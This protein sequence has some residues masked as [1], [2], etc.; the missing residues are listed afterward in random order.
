MAAV[1]W[2]NANLW[3]QRIETLRFVETSILGLGA[4]LESFI[5]LDRSLMNIE[6]I[7]RYAVSHEISHIWLGIHTEYLAKGKFFLGETIPGYVNL[8]YYESWAGDDAF[9]N[10]IQDKI[11]L[12]LSEVPFYTVAFEQ[13]LNQRKGS[14][15]ADDIIYHKGVA[16]VHEFRKLIGKEKLLKI[17][18]ETYSV[19]NHFVNLRD[20]EMNIK[21][22][23]C[24]N[25]YL[26]LFEIKL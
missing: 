8:L 3:Q 5:L 9:E 2:Y 14:F 15:Q 19:P 7:D 11:N 18:R 20:F 12:K 17:I 13:V 10:A 4:C 24:W 22:N 16:F 25:E 21:A 1:D 26:K 23:G 6:V